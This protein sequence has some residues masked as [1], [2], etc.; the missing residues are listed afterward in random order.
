MTKYTVI[1][2][3]DKTKGYGLLITKERIVEDIS[4]VYEVVKRLADECSKG[5]VELEFFD[6][7]LDSFLSDLQTF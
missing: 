1:S 2:P 3:P 7:I 6:D 5:G 4:P